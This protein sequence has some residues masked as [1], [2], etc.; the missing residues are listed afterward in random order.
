[1]RP[2]CALLAAALV[3]G[4]AHGSVFDVYGF[5]PRARAL[6]NALTADADD[7][8]G[9][10]YNPAMLTRRKRVNVGAG[11]VATFPRLQIDR[12]Y[13]AD[14][15]REI[16]NELPDDFT[17]ISFGAL[18]PLGGR[19]GN[20]VAIGFGLYLPLLRLLR[21]DS[22]DPQ[23][24]QFYRYE[25]LPDKFVVLASV[26]FEP[27]DGFSVGAGVQVLASLDGQLDFGVEVGNRRVSRREILVEIFPTAAPVFGLAWTP[28][29]GLRLGA[30][31]RG[32]I[33]LDYALPGHI[34]ID[35]LLQ[36]DLALSGTVLYTPDIYNLGVAWDVPGAGVTLTADASFARWSRAP[37]PSPHVALD[38]GGE[39]VDGLG[40]GE[41]LDI[42]SGAPVDLA[43]R[44]VL[45]LK[46]GAEYLPH[47][48]F[49]LRAGYT[50]RPSPAPV[51]TTAFNYIDNDAHLLAA[52]FGV[53]FA[54]PL[55]VRRNPVTL[56]FV[57]QATLMSEV[58]VHKAAGADDRVGDYTAGGVVHSI[59]LAF[60]HDL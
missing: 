9:T 24:P 51:P 19:F 47:P 10:F 23:V 46:A 12:R 17:G 38:V 34:D 8:T 4:P 13:Q 39:I 2:A 53:T 37:D 41:R 3:A 5:T 33:Q 21:A 55:E 36:L 29:A 22:V 28:A 54:D 57:Y 56:D 25:A 32:A 18:F 48:R 59:G 60:R 6:G 49:A 35:T 43:F 58:A 40:A 31:F 15:Q 44:D 45:E 11:L 14:F 50:W 27:V 20:R 7:Y 42:G 16:E 30:S 26:A 52:G 1:M